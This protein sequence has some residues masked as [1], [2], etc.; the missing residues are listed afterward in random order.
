MR[1]L[2]CIIMGAAPPHFASTC[3]RF[4]GSTV[5]ASLAWWQKVVTALEAEGTA[6]EHRLASL[7]VD[8]ITMCSK[9]EILSL[10]TAY[11]YSES[12]DLLRNR[13]IYRCNACEGIAKRLCYW[14]E[15]CRW[16]TQ[17]A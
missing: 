10:L 8:G 2:A 6:V 7:F 15:K 12:Y 9:V 4:L 13:I 1:Q 5:A 16:I 17:F 14:V 3:V 11:S